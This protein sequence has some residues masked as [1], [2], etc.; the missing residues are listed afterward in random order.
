MITKL[1]LGRIN[2]LYF[3]GSK[4]EISKNIHAIKSKYLHFEFAV[5]TQKKVFGNAFV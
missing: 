2:Y 4:I 5:Q 3:I 1:L